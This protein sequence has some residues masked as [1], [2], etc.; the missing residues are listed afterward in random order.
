M[1]SELHSSTMPLKAAEA[2][3]AA[4]VSYMVATVGIPAKA[5]IAANAA[6][7]AIGYHFVSI[8]KADVSA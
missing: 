2:A 3:K 8:T 6:K 5:A 4:K 1:A 7:A